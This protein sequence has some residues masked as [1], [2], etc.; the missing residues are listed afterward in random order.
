[1]PV[2]ARTL[3]IA[4]IILELPKAVVFQ[5]F[6]WYMT[7]HFL[8]IHSFDGIKSIHTLS[9][10]QQIEV[11]FAHGPFSETQLEGRLLHVSLSPSPRLQAPCEIPSATVACRAFLPSRNALSVLQRCI[12][13]CSSE[14][15]VA[16]T[17]RPRHSLPPYLVDTSVSL[18]IFLRGQ[19]LV[20]W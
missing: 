15:G 18:N 12:Q 7:V 9:I 6:M 4:I 17:L 11:G 3:K 13:L 2:G 8:P 19:E 10:Q 1:M 5:D 14:M 16:I 20:Y